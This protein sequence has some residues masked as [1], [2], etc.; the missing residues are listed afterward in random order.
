M[1]EAAQLCMGCMEARGPAPVCPRCGYNDA[2][3]L[4]T[5][6]YLKHRTVLKEQYLVGRMLGHGG[7]GITYLGWDL[8]LERKIAIK[9]YL[10][11]G[12]ASRI[13]GEAQV[14]AHSGQ[15]K[16]DFEW[17]LERFLD[18]ART[19]AKFQNH[20]GIVAVLNFFRENG[21]AYLI[22]D[23]L[24]GITLDEYLRRKN[25]R[26][27]FDR[28]LRILM[29]VMDAL[30]EVH[31]ANI[32]H[33]DI[34]PDNVYLCRSGPVKVLDFGAARHAISQ[35]SRNLSIILK[36]GYAPEEQY[37][38]K[39][40]QGPWTDVYAVAATLY[41]AITGHR[42]PSALDRLDTDELQSPGGLGVEMPTEAEA[43]L[44]KALAVRAVDRFATMED[45]QAAI[46]WPCGRGAGVNTQ[47]GAGPAAA[48]AV[49]SRIVS[50]IPEPD[51][52]TRVIS[53][54]L[55]AA[56]VS[57]AAAAAELAPKRS[58]P[59]W[60]FAV[61][62]GLAIGLVVML[63]I[64]RH[65]KP[66]AAPAPAQVQQANPP[67]ADTGVPAPGQVDTKRPSSM[68]VN[69]PS[70]APTSVKAAEGT[71]AAAP[72]PVVAKP[73]DRVVQVAVAHDHGGSFSDN[74]QGQLIV[75]GD[76]IEFR[77]SQHTFQVKKMDL[78]EAKMNNGFVR[79]LGKAFG[80]GNSALGGQNSFHIR[81]PGGKFNFVALGEDRKAG[82][83]TILNAIR[84]KP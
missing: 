59:K 27:G 83:A 69:A 60:M 44:V 58:F 34:S 23:Y 67:V 63:S 37:R 52:E 56:A 15:A 4:T 9:E 79:A 32:M 20:P 41:K 22:M 62:S 65:D 18:E 5:A 77:G 24:D 54:P 16:K 57:L 17:G 14:V 39:G 38:T 43:A 13:T 66:A 25:G 71:A 8:M 80:R 76:S 29:P 3:P 2:A 72:T 10:P 73:A 46:G 11:S 12:M 78:I 49:P 45:F 81:I 82:A 48:A 47:T 1:T 84:G 6:L 36:E 53:A 74:C 64:F 33:R 28:A 19:L 61:G 35:H 42:P 40:N 55:P 70:P 31:K 30:R 7:F 21:T 75:S 51:E 26:I 68:P 50:S